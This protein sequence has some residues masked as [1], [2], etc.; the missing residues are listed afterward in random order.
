MFAG[1]AFQ[2]T[3]FNSLRL[4]GRVHYWLQRSN[5]S[6]ACRFQQT[7]R[8]SLDLAGAL[9]AL[10]GLYFLTVPPGVSAA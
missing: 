3:G 6:A 4:E 7:P 1:Y 5:R 10:A 8:E 9:A 2:T